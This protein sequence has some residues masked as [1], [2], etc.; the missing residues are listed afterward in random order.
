MKSNNSTKEKLL[1]EAM[2]RKYLDQIGIEKETASAMIGEEK[3]RKKPNE[4][5]LGLFLRAHLTSI[6][7]ENLSQH[8]HPSAV[9]T[10][11]GENAD[12]TKETVSVQEIPVTKL[13][14]LDVNETLQN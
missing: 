1:S 6:P 12:G 3:S 8:V 9:V 13:P 10:V 5:N 11:D 14:S 2:L 7:F 4:S